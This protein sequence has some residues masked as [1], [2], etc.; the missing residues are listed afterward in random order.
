MSETKMRRR[1]VFECPVEGFRTSPLVFG[2]PGVPGV[3]AASM[4]IAEHSLL[5]HDG[6]ESV[7]FVMVD[8][9]EEDI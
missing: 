8:M 9:P 3:D 7:A 1:V 2:E 5:V 4:Q 6:D